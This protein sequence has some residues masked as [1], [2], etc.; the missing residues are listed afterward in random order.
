[1]PTPPCGAGTHPTVHMPGLASEQAQL[2]A[3]CGTGAG[4]PVP[5]QLPRART[6]LGQA[7]RDFSQCRA[8][9]PGEGPASFLPATALG[10]RQTEPMSHSCLTA[11][12]RQA[13]GR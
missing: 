1:M 6:Q 8:R 11:T 7:G 4:R 9:A 2:R 3:G 12:S 13:L 10:G 5:P